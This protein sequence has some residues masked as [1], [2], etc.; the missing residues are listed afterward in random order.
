M[1]SDSKSVGRAVPSS[2]DRKKDAR[3]ADIPGMHE[4]EFDDVVSILLGVRPDKL[5]KRKY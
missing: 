4:F 3:A 2:S 1:P 5:D